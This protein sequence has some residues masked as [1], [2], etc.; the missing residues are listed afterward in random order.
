MGNKFAA[1]NSSGLIT[2]FYDDVDS[3]APAGATTIEITEDEWMACLSNPGYTVV[4]GSLLPPSAASLLAQA[5][6]AQAATLSSA[7]QAAVQVDVSYTS[8]GGVTKTFQASSNSQSTLLVATTGYNL[9]GET[10]AGFYWVAADNTQV[11]FTLVDLKGLY[12]VMLAQGNAAFNKLQSLK[13]EV[14]AAT[15]VAAVQAVVWQ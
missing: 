3:P 9:A 7:Y 14:R 15:T 2:A 4:N 12:A 8:A 5:Q 10:P 6:A 11:P 1:F 13:S